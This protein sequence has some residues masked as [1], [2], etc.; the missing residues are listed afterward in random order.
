MLHVLWHFWC[1]ITRKERHVEP[2]CDRRREMG[3]RYHTW[4]KTAVIGLTAYWLAE[5]EKVQADV[6]N[7][8][9]H[10]HR[11]VGQT[12]CSL[13]RIFAPR[14]NNKLC[15]L[16]WNAEEAEVCNS[17]C[18]ECWLPPF[19][20]FT[21][22]LGRILLFRLKTSSPHLSGNKRTPAPYSPDLAPSDI[23]PLPTPKKFLDGKLFD[24]DDLKDAV[25][26]WLTSQAATFYEE[27]IQKLVP[28]YDKC[29][30]NGS[31]YVE[32]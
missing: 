25:H 28:H 14:H 11:I 29:L 30:N 6:F 17:K 22:T 5:K 7:T 3:V 4:I 9:D 12:R 31:E 10:V 16:L 8:E 32:K 13:G 19:F 27:G 2:Y 21:I 1:A 23:S 18:A 26:K 24:D 20:C 15:C